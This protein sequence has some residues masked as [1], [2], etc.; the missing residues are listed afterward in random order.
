MTVHVES[1]TDEFDYVLMEQDI[2]DIQAGE[3]EE[4]G[5]IIALKPSTK[6]KFRGIFD[7]IK[8]GLL[9]F[10]CYEKHK[11]YECS[12]WQHLLINIKY[13]WWLIWNKE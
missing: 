8:Y 1:K 10:W 12:Y 11:H 4:V 2:S 9:P 5:L 13:A 7:C 3:W 6:S